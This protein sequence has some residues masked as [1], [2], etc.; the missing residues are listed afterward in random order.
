MQIQ[1]YE[2]P[3][4]D[5]SISIQPHELL[6]DIETTGLSPEVSTVFMI[7][8]GFS[9]NEKLHTIHWMADDLTLE[10]EQS[11]LRSF[12]E[13]IHKYLS[14]QNSLTFI[15]FNG[16]QFDIPFLK[17]RF[18]QCS[19]PWPMIL[20]DDSILIDY[21]RIALRTKHLWPVPN[22]KLHSLASWL[23]YK[24]QK[25]PSGRQLIKS[26]HNYIKEKDPAVLNLLFL[27]NK[28]DLEALVHITSIQYYFD[29]FEGHYDVLSLKY[30]DTHTRISIDMNIEQPLPSTI[31]FERFGFHILMSEN[32]VHLDIP[33]YDQGLRFYYSD[34]KNYI[35]LTN[36]DYALHKSMATYIDK[37][38][39]VKANTENCY[40]W[41][42]PDASF[43]DNHEKQ[44]DYI[45]MVF[46]LLGFL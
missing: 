7:G 35:Y 38:Q 3:L 23:G 26:Y 45:Q 40:T 21:Y 6:L 8:C 33:V 10:S 31:E 27:H 42:S 12:S 41:F 15:T 43:F 46:R 9:K 11:V 29:V 1:T 28:Q 14:S 18:E 37:S 5:N 4:F 22:L 30:D 19:I 16:K 13:W 39:W 34:Y 36:E 20:N 2:L 25:T 24:Q 17:S 44:R 32:H